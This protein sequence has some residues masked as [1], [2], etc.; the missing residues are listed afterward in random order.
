MTFPEIMAA[1]LVGS[2]DLL[3]LS[4]P[5]SL[6]RVWSVSPKRSFPILFPCSEMKL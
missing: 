3:L 5:F 6:I 1:F 2:R 4:S